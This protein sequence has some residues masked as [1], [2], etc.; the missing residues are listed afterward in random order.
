MR[1]HERDALALRR[2]AAMPFIDRLE[3]AAVSGT[4]DRSAYDALAALERRGLAASIPHATG[5]LRT[6]RRYLL[7]A[8]GIQ[9]LASM[10]GV[11]LDQLLRR[12]PVSARWRRILLERLDS[13]AVIYRLASSIAAESGPLGLR[14]YRA[15]PLDAAMTLAD[16]RTLGVV[17]LGRTADRTGFAKRL[18][19][20]K[21]GSLPDAVLLLMP[22]EVRLRHTRRLLDGWRMPALLAL[23]ED[24]VLA[25][26]A[27]P[28]WRL[29]SVAAALDL[30]HVLSGH[31]E[32]SGRL[33]AEAGP[34][35]AALP[36]D[37]APDDLEPRGPGMES[38]G[39]LLP[40]A[41]KPAAKQLLDLLYDWPGI[42]PEHLRLLM[43]VSRARLYEIMGPATKAGLITRV[44]VGGRRLALSDWGLALL[45]RRDRAS[46]SAARKRWS[47]EPVDA[48]APEDWRNASG[49]NSRQ[50]LRNIEHTGAVHAFLASLNRQARSQGWELS[51]MDPPFRASRYFRHQGGLRSV[52]PD[53]FGVLRRGSEAWPFFLEW[54][55]RAVRPVTMAQRLAPYLRYYATPRPLD[56]HGVRPAVLVVFD[57]ELA[58]IHF[59]GL[60]EKALTRERVEVPLLV[61]HR[62]LLWREGP[63]GR[64]WRSP[65][66]WEVVCMLTDN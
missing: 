19:R 40:A 21:E 1:G 45:A 29:P 16:G 54:E 39:W 65:G 28:A 52:Y 64:A 31:V 10:E 6:T 33:P 59:L 47:V 25:G 24:A 22:D 5:L 46:V 15:A 58:A 53:A 34:K 12:R 36:E 61:S 42:A 23:E 63:L 2:L 30:H 35:R 66:S 37:I 60:A 49:R 9:L 11:Y 38:P 26:P 3:L 14:W 27:E 13:V 56:D 41:L 55:R 48:D 32:R 17:R 44:A 57:D 51:Q 18:W 7:T 62:E 20:L 4:A 50:L 8:D 43:G